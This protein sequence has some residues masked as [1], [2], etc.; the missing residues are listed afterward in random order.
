MNNYFKIV[1]VLGGIAVLV[2]GIL[3]LDI[4]RKE[5][6]V[7]FVTCVAAQ[8]QI[9]ES[10]P[11]QCR[12]DN[13]LIYTE[14]ISVAATSSATDMIVVDSPIASSTVSSPLVVTGSARGNWFFEASFPVRVFGANGIELGLGIAQAQGDWMTT[15]FVP[16]IATVE[17]DAEGNT[18]GYVRLSKD[19]PSGLP[20]YD[21]HVDVPLTFE[22]KNN[23]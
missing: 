15:E 2:Y 14:V 10:H 23:I 4:G 1:A 22:L 20:E 12:D 9:F 18:E 7:D 5:D 11:R 21:A 16:F 3:V 17:F 19:N 13:G 6:V 8:N